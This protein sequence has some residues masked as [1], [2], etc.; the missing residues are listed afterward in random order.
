LTARAL[1]AVSPLATMQRGFAILTRADD[2][3]IVRHSGQLSLGE[4]FDA[5]LADGLITARVTGKR[6]L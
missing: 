4:P 1:Q 5:R 3:A 6:P 2:G